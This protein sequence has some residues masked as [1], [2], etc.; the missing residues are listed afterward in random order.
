MH[1]NGELPR[2]SFWNSP[3]T[4]KF[5]AQAAEG[6][7]EVPG[8]V[9]PWRAM[10]D[11]MVSSN[12]KDRFPR[13]SY[14]LFIFVDLF[15]A[16]GSRLKKRFGPDWSDVPAREFRD[17]GLLTAFLRF[18]KEVI[19]VDRNRAQTAFR[20]IASKGLPYELPGG[21]VS[22]YRL[23]DFGVAYLIS[24]TSKIEAI[25]VRQRRK[26]DAGATI[27]SMED[28]G[29]LPHVILD[30][31][32]KD[33][34]SLLYNKICVEL[35]PLQSKLVYVLM[36]GDGRAVPYQVIWDEMYPKVAYRSGD[37]GPPD[38]LK[39]HKKDVNGSLRM[40]WGKPKRGES[41]IETEKFTGYFLNRS[42]GWQ[43]AK[44]AKP[45]T[46]LFFRSP[47]EIDNSRQRD[48]DD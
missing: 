21:D 8:D 9:E 5:I 15:H 38:V 14:C 16:Y 30:W 35:T 2:S 31:F 24:L 23:N 43:H 13:C 39:T 25:C 48:D 19:A 18:L 27:T 1:A 17:D 45:N 32:G 34:I 36:G 44:E 22:K 28:R 29:K 37:S 6:K 20:R 7:W 42:V 40:A 4:K 46:P 33:R 3:G 11:L 26:D 47:N 41:W 12:N 10:L